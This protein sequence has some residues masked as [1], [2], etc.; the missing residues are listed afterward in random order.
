M[1]TRLGFIVLVS[2]IVVGRGTNLGQGDPNAPHVTTYSEA[3]RICADR[4]QV[5]DDDGWQQI[6]TNQQAFRDAGFPKIDALS[7]SGEACDDSHPFP[8]DCRT[9]WR[10][11][12]DAVWSDQ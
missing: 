10:A 7:A 9:C 6:L 4:L 5:W 11:I 2:P 12:I 3:R 8:F 1:Y